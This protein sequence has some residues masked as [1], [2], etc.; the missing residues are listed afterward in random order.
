[1]PN[2]AKYPHL[3]L[4]EWPFQIIPSPTFYKIWAGRKEIKQTLTQMFKRAQE[5]DPS[6]IYLLWGYFGAGKTH[7]LKYFQWKLSNDK[8]NPTLIGYHEFPVAVKRFIEV[9]RSFISKINF[10]EIERVAKLVYENFQQEYGNEA[11]KV[12]NEKISNY[13]DDFTNAIIALAH[14]KEKQ[15]IH[16]WIRAEN[17]YITELRKVNIKKRLEN[18]EDIFGLFGNLVRLLTYKCTELPTFK[19][20]IWMIDDFQKIEDLKEDY[21][22]TIRNGLNSLFNNCPE[23]FCL[24][25]S[26][27]SRGVSA[28]KGLLSEA[29][30]E[31]LPLAPYVTIPPMSKEEAKDFVVDLLKQFRSEEKP[32]DDYFPFSSESLDDI[33][34]FTASRGA[35]LPRNVM[36]SLNEVLDKAE[37]L[38]KKKELDRIN[39]DF[40]LKVLTKAEIL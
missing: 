34:D 7:S 19:C 24:V 11:E 25:L 29:L 9:Y 33:I 18:D 5:R 32:P 12:F 40:A 16:R 14:G 35:L 37:G 15:T 22:N 36:R 23:R 38:I 17:V 30:I 6:T 26:F 27:T 1:M 13:N 39:S 2:E 21:K 3:Y 31:R 8:E 28:I 20:V 10:Q 4:K